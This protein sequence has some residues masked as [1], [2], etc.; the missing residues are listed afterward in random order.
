MKACDNWRDFIKIIPDIEKI[1]GYWVYDNRDNA[2]Y[3]LDIEYDIS[4]LKGVIKYSGTDTFNFKS[5]TLR[6][7]CIV[8]LN[9]LIL[10]G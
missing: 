9:I 7:M 3:L 2:E 8:I 1:H 4:I 5:K 10:K 6:S